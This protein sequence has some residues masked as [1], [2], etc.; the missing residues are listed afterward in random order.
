MS[1]GV[2]RR[3]TTASSPPSS[4]ATVDASAPSS[5]TVRKGERVGE[6]SGDGRRPFF[7]RY[8]IPGELGPAVSFSPSPL[9]ASFDLEVACVTL[10]PTSLISEL[11]TVQGMGAWEGPAPTTSTYLRN[12]VTGSS[13]S[14]CMN[15]T[16]TVFRLLSQ[17]GTR[18]F[19][20]SR[21]RKGTKHDP[22]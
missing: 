13:R 18:L 15:L 10:W 1:D 19:P 14:P 3:S 12:T 2:Q 4:P 6:R 11:P 22:V 20:P 21:I 16:H 7:P 5:L 9:A 8:R 17:R